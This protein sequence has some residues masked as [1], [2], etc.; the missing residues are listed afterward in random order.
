MAWRK[1]ATYGLI[2]VDAGVTRLHKP[3]TV[4]YSHDHEPV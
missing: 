3:T 1:Q 2:V 4:L